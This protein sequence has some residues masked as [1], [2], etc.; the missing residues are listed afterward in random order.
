MFI[1]AMQSY[2]EKR[3]QML[4]GLQELLPLLLFAIRK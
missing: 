3:E 4:D 2:N 1:Y